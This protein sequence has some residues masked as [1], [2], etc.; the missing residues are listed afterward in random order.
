[1]SAK[2]EIITD[3]R[4]QQKHADRVSIFLDGRFWKGISKE[5][6][7]SLNLRENQRVDSDELERI[8]LLEER[9][10]ARDYSIK[11]L[12][13][14]NRSI[15]ELEGRLR[16]SGFSE[17]V[18]RQTIDGLVQ[19]EYLDDLVFTR[20]W[21]DERFRLKGLGKNRVRQELLAKGIDKATIEAEL[22]SYSDQDEK[23]CALVLA[24]KKYPHIR[25]LDPK[26]QRQRLYQFLI[27]RGFDVSIASEILRKITGMEDEDRDM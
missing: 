19:Q 2:T 18:I 14:R 16:K 22:S 8:I 10:K 12:G 21:M 1:M 9:K 27:Y 25:D 26:K 15:R 24:H 17:E 23:K 11:L 20:T 5:V 3:M 13:F 4:T 6:A 7:L